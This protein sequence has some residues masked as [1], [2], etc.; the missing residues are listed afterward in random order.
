MLA[1]YYLKNHS[2]ISAFWLGLAI[3]FKIYPI[4]YLPSILLTIRDRPLINLPVL[5]LVNLRNLL[6]LIVTVSTLAG[7]NYIMYLQYGFEFLDHSY[8]YHLVRLDHRHNFSIYNMA[9]YYKS[10]L[11]SIDT[12]DIEKIVF[13][14]QLALS[15]IIVPLVLARVDLLSSLFIQTFIFVTFNKVMTSQ[16]FIWF[17]IFLPHYL[18]KSRLTT[19]NKRIG[20]LLLVL[21]IGSQSSWL[22]FAYQIELELYSPEG[23]RIDGR[24]WNEL[25]NF[26]CKINTHPNLSD[27]SSYIEQGNTKIIC[28]VQ[29]PMEPISK[30]QSN[31]EKARIEINLTITNFATFERKKR[32]KNEKRIIELRNLLEKT[33]D[34]SIMTHLYPKTSIIINVQV[35]S[36][37]GGMLSA[38]TNAI[39][40]AII[41]AGI[42]MYDYV[43]AISCGLYDNTPILDLNNLEENE[44]PCLTLGVIGKSE[45]LALLLFEDKLPLDYLENLLSIGIAGSHRI[46]DLMDSEIRKHGNLRASKLK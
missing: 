41:D 31:P 19:T 5:K 34:Q 1:L 33:F 25:R 29:G 42:S 22:Y 24:R 3:H 27:G 10:A 4:I 13:I 15:A 7:I 18:S 32:N 28:T 44:M 45:K 36:Q 11:T 12:F 38:V 21:W 14:P 2:V 23:L 39:T 16:Y 43:S 6:Y 35:L 37:D 8:L 9:L 26:N 17:L 20:I 40:L 46:K 30:S